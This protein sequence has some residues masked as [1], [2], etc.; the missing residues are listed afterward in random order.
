MEKIGNWKRKKVF[1]TSMQSWRNKKTV[2]YLFLYREN[3]REDKFNR[4][5]E[6][7][8]VW[9]GKSSGQNKKDLGEFKTK[10]LAIEFIKKWM[11]ENQEE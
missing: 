3:F 11:E 5:K 7:W 10:K 2:S 9:I 1:S 8:K 6:M 4:N